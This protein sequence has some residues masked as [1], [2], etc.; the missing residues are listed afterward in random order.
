VSSDA[1]VT[2]TKEQHAALESLCTDCHDNSGE[3]T[4][5]TTATLPRATVINMLTNVSFGRMPKDDPMDS[6]DRKQF[7][8]RFIPTL[9]TGADAARARAYLVDRMMALPAFRPEVMFDLIEQRVGK[10]GGPWRTLEQDGR[11]ADAQVTPGLVTIFGVATV[12]ACRAAHST[13][14]EIDRCLEAAV[15]PDTLA[16][17]PR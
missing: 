2:L 15:L 4:D 7:L 3:I 8:E 16:I 12:E 5:F 1:T 17:K 14:E 6:V 13:R 11:G 9:W 10:R